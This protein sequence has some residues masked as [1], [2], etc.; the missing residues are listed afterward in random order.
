MTN[1]WKW[2]QAAAATVGGA[3]AYFMGGL[4]NL[5]IALIIFAA[6]DYITG[7]SAAI[8]AKKLSSEIGAKGILKK[9]LMFLVVGIANIIDVRLIGAGSAFR[10]ATIIF[11]LSNEG[12]SLLE[13]AGR[14]GLPI[15]K[16]LKDILTQLHDKSENEEEKEKEEH[17]G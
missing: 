1:A 6:V 10:T 9:V 5:L 13:N 3:I 11:Y 2:I 7:V 8:M 14:C 16:K 17:N 15:P 12:I 4:D